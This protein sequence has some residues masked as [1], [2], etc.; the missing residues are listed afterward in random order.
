MKRVRFER[1]S[2]NRQ[3][4]TSSTLKE[5]RSRIGRNAGVHKGIVDGIV[6]GFRHTSIILLW[7]GAMNRRIFTH[8][9]KIKTEPLNKMETEMKFLKFVDFIDADQWRGPI[10]RI[11]YLL[12]FSTLRIR[13]QSVSNRL[14]NLNSILRYLKTAYGRVTPRRLTSSG[15]QYR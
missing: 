6:T 15:Q 13:I 5:T 12:F 10:Y 14:I 8:L 11:E 1:G 2:F 3:R 4:R 9:Q 7:E